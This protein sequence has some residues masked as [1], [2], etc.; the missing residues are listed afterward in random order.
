KEICDE[1]LMGNRTMCPVCDN[2]LSCKSW[3]LSDSCLY[4]KIS[5]IIDNP[6]T[7][8]YSI[9]MSIWA[10]LFIEFWKR[11][12]YELQFEW[13]VI[14]FE[15]KNEPLRPDFENQVKR[16]RRNRI[17]GEEELYVPPL[18]K[19][20][21]YILSVSMIL[22]MMFLVLA[23]VMGFILYRLSFIVAFP[24]DTDP[25]IV[26]LTTSISAGCINLFLIV[27]LNRFYSWLAVKLNDFELHPT[28]SKYE[29]A[30]TIKMYLFEFVNYYASI[31]YIAFFK[32]KFKESKLI[33]KCDQSGCLSE[34]C[35]Q[36]AIIMIGKQIFNNIQ[37][38]LYPIVQNCLTKLTSSNKWHKNDHIQD[39]LKDYYLI[40][41]TNL[42]LFAEYLEMVIQYGFI[43]IF[44]V[45][46]PLGPLFS[47]MNNVIEIRIDAFKILTQ[48]KR[49]LPKKAQDIGMWHRILST[50]SNLAVI[51]NGL[52]L[53]FT[54]DFIPR[55]VYKYSYENDPNHNN[56]KGYVEFTLSL[57]KHNSNGIEAECYYKDFRKPYDSESPY[58]YTS[59]FYHIL[60]AR[61]IFLVIFE[62]F[63]FSMVA[64]M[65]WIP[66]VPSI[67]QEKI[68]AEN[69]IIQ[70]AL[71]ESLPERV[72]SDQGKF[73]DNNLESRILIKDI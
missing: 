26:N 39:W 69:L 61:V 58:E 38:V 49:P 48:Y 64:V 25:N 16:T 34:L 14:D 17:T 62:H 21:R 22:L 28:D 30:L 60:A 7:V 37:E 73:T 68:D 8:F 51:T 47:L 63:V 56:L 6:L 40:S 45:A 11:K 42:T 41:W 15:K 50:I 57:D 19:F 70:H 66:D 71:W 20:Y 67:V 12:Q 2:E 1:N 13:D 24:K 59:V 4:S 43:T 33:E 23:L 3:K 29:K 72:V 55:L 65:H 32:G 54:S 9:F 44:A 10:V 18:T 36:L 35:I 52:I 5:Y 46:F 31:F 27:L 53:A